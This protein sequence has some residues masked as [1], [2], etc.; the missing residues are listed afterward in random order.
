VTRSGVNTSSKLSECRGI[1]QAYL[2]RKVAI[3]NIL[4]EPVQPGFGSQ[5]DHTI[6]AALHA[7]LQPF[8][9]FLFLI[10]TSVRGRYFERT[11]ITAA[12][13]RFEFVEQLFGALLQLEK[14]QYWDGY[15]ESLQAQPAVREAMVQRRRDHPVRHLVSALQTQLS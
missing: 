14:G 7:F 8:I 5:P 11:D 13:H 3:A 15:L 12:V 10:E 6:D 4:A 2:I 1:R 9:S